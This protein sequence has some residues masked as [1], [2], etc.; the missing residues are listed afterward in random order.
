MNTWIA[1]FRGINVGGRNILPMAELVR[2]LQSLNLKDIRTYIQSGN[3]VFRTSR[4]NPAALEKTI[5]NVVE[6]G[7]GFLPRVVIFDRKHLQHVIEANPFPKVGPKTLVVF[8]LASPAAAPDI[9]AMKKSVRLRSD[10]I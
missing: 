10:F 4:K 8:F 3:V 9:A 5:A 7:H 6:A 2:D 1:L